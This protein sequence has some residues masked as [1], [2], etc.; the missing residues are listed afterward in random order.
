MTKG[1]IVTYC[2]IARCCF[3]KFAVCVGTLGLIGDPA[4][5]EQK[6]NLL[7]VRSFLKTI[8]CYDPDAENNCLTNDD[9]FIL[10]NRVSEIPGLCGDPLSLAESNADCCN[11]LNGVTIANA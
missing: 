7:L 5:A 8:A 1:Q 10:I 4:F 9:I 11:P 6:R 2:I 3:A